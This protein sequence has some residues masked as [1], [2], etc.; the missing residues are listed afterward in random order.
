MIT[1]DDN[2]SIKNY[3]NSSKGDFLNKSKGINK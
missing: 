2:G 3:L 1:V